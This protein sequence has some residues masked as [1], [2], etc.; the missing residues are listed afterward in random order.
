MLSLLKIH[1][2]SQNFFTLSLLKRHPVKAVM[3]NKST[4]AYI[5]FFF[6][7]RLEWSTEWLLDGKALNLLRSSDNRVSCS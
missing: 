2:M 4:G 7:K 5:C 1:I 3:A 6:L